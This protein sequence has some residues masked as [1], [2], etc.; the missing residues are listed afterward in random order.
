MKK[1]IVSLIVVALTGLLFIAVGALTATDVPEDM[2]I[3]NQVY[4]K[5]KKGPGK[6]LSQ[7][8]QRRL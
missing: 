2:M 3:D 5:E 8:T 4:K 1:G 6:T 7:K